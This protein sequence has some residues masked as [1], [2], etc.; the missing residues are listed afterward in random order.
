M[1]EI[2]QGLL[3]WIS[4]HPLWAHVAVFLIAL[5][6]SLAVV[7]LVVPGVIMMLGAGAL[8][9]TGA[10]EFLPVCLWAVA[11]AIAGDGLSYWIGRHYKDRLRTLWPF[12][13]YPETL[14]AGIRFF[15]R[16]GGKSVALGRFV[17]PVRAVVPLVAGMLG[18]PPRRFLFANV[19]SAFAWAPGYLLPGIVFGAS[20][21][22]AAEA[23]GRLVLV[24]IMVVGG[25]WLTAWGVREL[26]LFFSPRANRLL[27][28][29]LRW[30]DLH[31]R[32]GEL[33]HALADPDH[34]DARTL[35]A[36]AA[37]LILATVFFALVIGLTLSD[38]AHLPLNRMVRDFALSLHTPVAD[39][40]MY[41]V[42]SLGSSALVFPLT[43]VVYGYLHWFGRRGHATYWLAAS[44]FALF[45]GPLLSA[46]AALV[47]PEAVAGA[48]SA[49]SF[50]SSSVLRATVVYGFLALA[51]A[52]GFPRIWAWLPYTGASTLVVGVTIAELYFGN[53]WLTDA[54]GAIALGLIWLATL[55]LAL[56]SHT[57]REPV[58]P[59]LGLVTLATIALSLALVSIVP[60]RPGVVAPAAG[61][62]VTNV[63][64]AAW[65]DWLWQKLPS[66]RGDLSGQRRHPLDLQY[67]GSLPALRTKLGPERWTD[68]QLLS[69]GNL[70]KLLSPS[71]P[72]QKL[73]VVPQLHDAHQEA[74]ILI[75]HL[76]R[77]AR[78]VLRLWATSYRIDPPGEP[79]WIGNVTAQRKRVILDWFVIPATAEDFRSPLRQLRKDLAGV[80]SFEPKGREKPPFLFELP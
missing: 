78:L 28:V 34:P 2:I 19:L 20:L 5:T 53:R 62:A 49:W 31:P 79:L 74:I 58:S 76:P 54:V 1:A 25:I 51:L 17:G 56:R 43:L 48:P 47:S 42:G 23:A 27:Q 21:E 36:L 72:L 65:H 38:A 35:A 8:I 44:V 41:A 61:P 13:G 75:K 60:T 3:A 16:Y 40:L 4:A 50:P 15:E 10:L 26:F 55:G 24:L 12:S 18:M 14:E 57:R 68:P 67:A 6:E 7:G 59:T 39:H 37:L 63:D 71:L 32:F 33:A 45:A 77:D 69:L 64:Q 46:V 70:M 29:L 66:L 9:A 80:R 11:G 30:S 73:P 22:L 52:S